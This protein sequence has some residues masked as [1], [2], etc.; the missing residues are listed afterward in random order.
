MR[1]ERRSRGCPTDA[2]TRSGDPIRWSTDDWS[3]RLRS[4]AAG[5]FAAGALAFGAGIL[6][7]GALASGG[8]GPPE[9]VLL[10]DGALF[11]G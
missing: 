5:A 8:T 9:G 4:L 2:L 1:N 11:P 7:A 6:I 10:P 3:L